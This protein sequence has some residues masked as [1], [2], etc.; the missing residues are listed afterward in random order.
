[1]GRALPLLALLALAA[2]AQD[3]N[4][5]IAPVHRPVVANGTAS[6]PGCPDWSQGQVVPSAGAAGRNFGCATAANLAAMVADPQDLARGRDAGPASDPRVTVK[7]LK[8]WR[9]ARTTG[10]GGLK[11]ESIK[12]I[13]SSAGGGNP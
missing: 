12:D 3:Q 9:D 13:S 11:A 2:C 6:V 7:A 8:A 4:M 5:G 10:E 1:M